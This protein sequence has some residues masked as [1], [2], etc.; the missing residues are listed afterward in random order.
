MAWARAVKVRQ[1]GRVPVLWLFTDAARLADPRQAV[2]ALPKGLCGVVLRHDGDPARA[3]LGRDLAA[4]CRERRLMLTVAADRRLAAS[5]GAGLHLRGGRGHAPKPPRGMVNTA[6]AHTEAELRRGL[7]R[8]AAVF[9]SPLLP[10]RSHPGA[11]VLGPTRWRHL[12]GHARIFALGGIDGETVRR[13][14]RA[15]AGAGAIGVFA[16]ES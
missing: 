10:T 15:A 11:P 5:L 6:S 7:A 3:E 4:I 14:P 2:R 13:I 16:P 9:L 8:G 12:A 1:G